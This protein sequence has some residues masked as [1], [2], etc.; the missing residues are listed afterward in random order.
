MVNHFPMG[1]LTYSLVSC[2]NND[3]LKIIHVEIG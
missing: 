1:T 2:H 3:P